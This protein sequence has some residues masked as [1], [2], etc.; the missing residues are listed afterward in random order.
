LVL[1][2]KLAGV[3]QAA[4]PALDDLKIEFPKWLSEEFVLEGIIH[5]DPKLEV[6]VEQIVA[7]NKYLRF[8]PVNAH[9]VL[10]N[11]AAKVKD[12]KIKS[13]LLEAVVMRAV[14]GGMDLSLHANT[15]L[16]PD[17]LVVMYKYFENK[18]IRP[19]VPFLSGGTKHVKRQVREVAVRIILESDPNFINHLPHLLAEPEPSLSRQ[20]YFL[21]GQKRSAVVEKI[22]IN[23][24][25]STL[26]LSIN[27]SPELIMLCYRTL[28]LTAV[29]MSALD[30][31]AGKLMKKD[32]R[33]FIGF[34]NETTQTH[35]I[36]GALALFLMPPSLGA[37]EI[38]SRAHGS[39]FRSLRLAYYEA[40]KEADSYR[41]RFLSHVVWK[42]T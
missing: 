6:P 26:D 32:F 10:I 18:D 28:G 36:G 27:R 38:L 16:S 5:T 1:L 3:I 19:V 41:R 29:S 4:S 17:D 13:Q 20:I 23:F 2:K 25:N 42:T 14:H 33:S 22:L 8:L 15:M 37:E 12:G 24:L 21:L 9:K 30:F 39:F 34:S 7:L 35:R 31:A 40:K 11:I